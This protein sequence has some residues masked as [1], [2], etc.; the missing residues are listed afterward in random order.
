VSDQAASDR[1]ELE[2]VVDEHFRAEEAEDIE[3]LVATF[4]EDAEHDGDGS[5]R[6]VGRRAIGEFYR[7]LFPVIGGHR[8]T[9]VRRLFGPG[10]VVDEADVHATA[11]GAPFGLAVEG[12][13]R[14]VRFRL[15][16]VFEF[17]DG[18]ISR[19]Q[20]WLDR[21]DIER[22]LSTPAAPV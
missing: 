16:H 20:G 14:V 3:A 4:T 10:L 12:G 21:K 18:L 6:L 15:L 22:Q 8:F 5:Q 1:E 11:H 17:R 7:A 9:T 2:R 13:G 19:E